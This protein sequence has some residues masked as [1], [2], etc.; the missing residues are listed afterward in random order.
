MWG[1]LLIQRIQKTF[2]RE[3]RRWVY[4]CSLYHFDFFMCFKYII[5]KC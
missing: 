3:A 1:D 4:R 2:T 5:T